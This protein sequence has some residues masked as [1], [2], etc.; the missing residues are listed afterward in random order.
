MRI[1]EILSFLNNNPKGEDLLKFSYLYISSTKKLMKHNKELRKFVRE[2]R[3]EKKEELKV[4]EED[5]FFL[6][7]K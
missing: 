6:P 1:T 4:W 2:S 7:K 5:I 3:K